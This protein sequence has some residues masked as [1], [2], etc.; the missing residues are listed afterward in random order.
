MDLYHVIL[1]VH[2]ITLVVAAST[3]TVVKLAISRRAHARTL[4]DA[5][6]WHGVITSASKIFPVC[7]AV[8]VITGGYM[9]TAT[10]IHP[11]SAG[12]VVAGLVGV[13][14]LLASGVF[15]GT[16]GRALGQVLDGMAKRGLDQPAPTLVASPF[17]AALPM[18]NTGVALSVAFDMVIKPASIPVALSILAIGVAIGASVGV[19]RPVRVAREATAA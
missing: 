12:F 4:G 9:L 18:I 17:V 8:F 10:G 15:L 3:T 14:L 19:R 11:W 5:I 7:L 2:I 16:K 1:F 6:D 13:V